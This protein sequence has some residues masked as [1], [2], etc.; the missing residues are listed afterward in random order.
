MSTTGAAGDARP[1][2][3][4]AREEVSA[5]GVVYR[6]VDGEPH[7]L[8]IRDGYQN[9]GFPK[10]HLE[11]G[12]DAA[13]AAVRE[14]AEETGLAVVVI[15]GALDTIDWHF[16]LKGRL[17]HKVCHF[18]LMRADEGDP[19]PQQDEGISDCRWL[20]FDV[21][22]QRLSYANARDVLRQAHARL[23]DSPPPPRDARLPMHAAP[24]LGLVAFA[25]RERVRAALQK[26][27]RRRV[28]VTLTSDVPAFRAA[29]RSQ[30]VDAVL[31]DLGAGDVA[32]Q[33]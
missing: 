15:E 1:G 20:A 4:A 21:A 19:V 22:V 14:V 7:F 27:P 23:G 16:R 6:R 2:R 32:W 8:L 31:V 24:P 17:V 29:L 9:W 18:F 26:L 33:A 10:G 13:A 5:G 11:A 3:R 12:E 28:H 25:A 30:L